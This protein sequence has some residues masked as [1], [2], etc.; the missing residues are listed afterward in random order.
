MVEERGAVVIPMVEQEHGINWQEL[1][2]ALAAPFPPEEVEWRPQGKTAPGKRVQVVPY[3]DARAVQDRLDAVVG[4]GGWSFELEPVAVEGGELKVARGRLTIYG[5]T[6]DDIGVASTF[7]A[8][9]GCAS[10]A[11]RRAA[12]QWGIARYLYDLPAVWVELDD[13]GAI[14]QEMRARLAEALRRRQSSAA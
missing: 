6:K 2:A 11:L 14:P 7:E 12:V 5:V 9:K 1:G 4:V 8:S 3:V 10:S 13:R